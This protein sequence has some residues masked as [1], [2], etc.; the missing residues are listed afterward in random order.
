MFDVPVPVKTVVGCKS[1]VAVVEGDIDD[2]WFED[3]ENVEDGQWSWPALY[4][5]LMVYVSVHM[6]KCTERFA[7][8]FLA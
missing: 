3:A 4:V 7:P 2:V 5:H 8:F 6:W 1:V